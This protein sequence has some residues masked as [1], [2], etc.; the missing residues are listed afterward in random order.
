MNY[1]YSI[2]FVKAFSEFLDKDG[3]KYIITDAQGD[4]KKQIADIDD[5]VNRKVSMIAIFFIILF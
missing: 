4:P 3:V 1:D 5:L 2:N